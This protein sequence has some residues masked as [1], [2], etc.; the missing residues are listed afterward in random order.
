MTRRPRRVGDRPGP[1]PGP[2]PGSWGLGSVV[3]SSEGQDLGGAP[4]RPS[5]DPSTSIINYAMPPATGCGID[6]CL[7]VEN[8]VV[9]GFRFSTFLH[10]LSH[11]LFLILSDLVQN[12][13]VIV[14]SQR[15]LL[16]ILPMGRKTAWRSKYSTSLPRARTNGPIPCCP[17]TAPQQT[18]LWPATRR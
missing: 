6:C 1:G 13:T 14:R 16:A 12:G 3:G 15:M 10:I 7:V 2:G 17:A 5:I 11:C 18:P 9:L 4:H 8:S